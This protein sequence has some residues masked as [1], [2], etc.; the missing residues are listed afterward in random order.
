MDIKYR[1]GK[2]GLL[3]KPGILPKL[4]LPRV[5]A[6]LIEKV[7]GNNIVTIAKSITVTNR[8]NIKNCSLTM[9]NPSKT[10]NILL[11]LSC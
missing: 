11:N 10:T 5:G 1:V 6:Y 9:K 4:V 2:L 8:V 3:K 7:H